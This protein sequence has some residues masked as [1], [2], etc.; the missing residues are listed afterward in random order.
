M[1][2][3]IEKLQKKAL[4]IISF[5]YFR[6]LS[7]LL[8]KERVILEMKDIVEMQDILLMDSFSKGKLPESFE[9]FFKNLF[10]FTPNLH[11]SAALNVQDTT[12]KSVTYSTNTSFL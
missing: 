8:S 12:L 1:R 2:D 3:K 10:M 11:D 4:R 6:E 9:H 7:S 5:I